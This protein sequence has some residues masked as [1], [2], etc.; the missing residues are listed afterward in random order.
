[1]ILKEESKLIEEKYPKNIIT[2]ESLEKL[3]EHCLKTLR[4]RPDNEEHSLVLALL[5]EYQNRIPRDRVKE[6]IEDVKEAQEIEKGTTYECL[7]AQED[8]L[9]ELLG[10]DKNA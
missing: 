2:Q 6:M 4:Y 3:E 5:Y 10:S 8:I 7:V 1:M 9:K